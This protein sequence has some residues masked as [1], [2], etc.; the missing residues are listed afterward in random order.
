MPVTSANMPALSAIAGFDTINLFNLGYFGLT[1]SPGFSSNGDP[2]KVG[3]AVAGAVQSAGVDPAQ[4]GIKLIEAVAQD[5]AVSTA[6]LITA[7][8]A[9]DRGLLPASY[10]PPVAQSVG[11]ASLALSR[12]AR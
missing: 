4:N 1:D 7:L 9:F 8:V 10:S 2:I 5:N 6:T 12:P 11:A 3:F